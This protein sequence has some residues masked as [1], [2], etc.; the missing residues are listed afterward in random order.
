MGRI[1][2]MAAPHSGAASGVRVAGSVARD[3]GVRQ[4]DDV[5]AGRPGL[6]RR[7]RR[8]QRRADQ[9]AQRVSSSA[10]GHPRRHRR[11]GRAEAA[12]GLVPSRTGCSRTPAE[13]ALATA[14]PLPRISRNG[15]PDI[16]RPRSEPGSVALG[17]PW[18]V[19]RTVRAAEQADD[20]PPGPRRAA[21]H[22]VGVR[23]QGVLRTRTRGGLINEY[24]YPA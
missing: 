12:G 9:P 15:K 7:L 18:A 1:T 21:G 24:Q 2:T 20:D 23:A 14:Y 16:G 5:G 19:R 11:A 3:H 17:R 8:A 10:V 13:Q 22:Q 4:R 6:R